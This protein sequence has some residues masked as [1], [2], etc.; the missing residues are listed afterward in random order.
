MRR[1]SFMLMML[2]AG[3]GLAAGLQQ[4]FDS[5]KKPPAT[6]PQPRPPSAPPQAPQPPVK[7]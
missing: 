4:M 5:L 6:V 1:I 7:K 3:T 2:I